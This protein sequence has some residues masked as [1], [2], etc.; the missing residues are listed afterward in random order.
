[1]VGWEAR[2]V[3]RMGYELVAH[4]NILVVGDR[5]F[6][7]DFVFFPFLPFSS[8]FLPFF[9]LFFSFLFFSFSQTNRNIVPRNIDIKQR[10]I[11]YFGAGKD[12]NNAR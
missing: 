7:L 10:L 8:L 2:R 4:R 12:K 6:L 5:C 9:F 11:C 3:E 1:M